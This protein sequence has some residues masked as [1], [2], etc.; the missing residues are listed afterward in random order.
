MRSL[1]WFKMKHDRYRAQTIFNLI[2][3]DSLKQLL[4]VLTILSISFALD[5]ADSCM[6]PAYSQD[7]FH[8][9]HVD[10][11]KDRSNAANQASVFETSYGLEAFYRYE[12]VQDKGGWY[13]VYVG[14][15]D[16]ESEAEEMA[17]TLMGKNRI[18]HYSIGTLE[19]DTDDYCLHVSSY[20]IRIQAEEEVHR[21]EKHG[22]K[23]FFAEEKVFGRT[24]F[25][26]YI[27]AFSDEK[28]ARKIGAELNMRGIIPFFRPKKSPQGM[29]A[30]EKSAL[31]EKEEDDYVGSTHDGKYAEEEKG[32]AYYDFGVFA[33]EDGDYEDAETNLLMALR[34]NPD[35]PF[36]NHFLGKTYLKMERYQ[37]AENCLNKAWKVNPDMSGLGYDL[38]FLNYKM[39]DYLRAA[40]LFVEIATEDPPNVLAHYHAGISL[41]KLER[42]G[43]AL[44]YFISAAEMS[45]SIKANG[46]YYA[47]IC[48]WKMGEIEKAA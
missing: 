29:I 15:F 1:L 3:R 23:A 6:C 14:R 40:E 36:C 16:S 42:F 37:K 22:F 24:W 2:P 19:Q 44:N 48:Y 20:M 39:S 10:A 28:H 13:R 47:G 31:F 9:I 46:Y 27:G 12:T 33:Y 17:K 38:A 18:P 8:S 43:K 34:F 32:G 45:P 26:V 35:D 4:K 5:I 41:Y 21:L 7:T 11:Y 30:A 25:R